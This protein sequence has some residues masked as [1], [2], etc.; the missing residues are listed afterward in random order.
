MENSPDHI[1]M[2]Q[3]QQAP[4]V[5]ETQQMQ[6]QQLLFA[7]PVQQ[8]E[9]QQTSSAAHG[10]VEKSKSKTSVLDEGKTKKKKHTEEPAAEEP[11]AEEPEYVYQLERDQVRNN[12]SD[13]RVDAFSEVLRV[14]CAYDSKLLD[15]H[16][17]IPGAGAYKKMMAAIS[18]Y[19]DLSHPDQAGDTGQGPS[20]RPE[21]DCVLSEAARQAEK[22]RRGHQRGG[23]CG[24]P[25]RAV[26]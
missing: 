18:K 25:V 2:K 23:R 3:Q 1:Q 22:R 11:A 24:R 9:H 13:K 14:N 21:G 16:S 15:K 4:L 17:K 19:A 20:G 5:A 8:Q 26:F 6:S 12:F 7:P 10:H